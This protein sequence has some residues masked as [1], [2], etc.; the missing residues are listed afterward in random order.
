MKDIVGGNFDPGKT[1]TMNQFSD[2]EILRNFRQQTK[3]LK[4]SKSKDTYSK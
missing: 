3:E 4:E 1:Y 2:E